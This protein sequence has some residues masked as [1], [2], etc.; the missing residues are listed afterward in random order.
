MFFKFKKLI[1]QIHLWLGL[2][3]GLIVFTVAITG[4]IWTFESE[5]SDLLYPYRKVEVQQNK[6]IISI[7]GVKEKVKPYLQKINNIYYLGKNRTI[8]V[9][10]WNEMNG[11]LINNYVYLNPYTGE[12]L[13]IKKDDPSFFDVVLELHTSLLLGDTGT[14]IVRY[15]TLIFL[16][17]LISGIFLWWPRNKLN[18][19]QRLKFDW[20]AS[21]KWKRKNY[22]LHSILGFY[23]CWIIIFA[24]ITGLAWGFKWVDRTIYAVATLG[25]PFKDYAAVNSISN[26]GFRH[27]PDFDDSVLNFAFTNY[28]KPVESWYYYFPQN[29]TEAISLYLN[30]D[31]NTWYKATNYF[32]DQRTGKLLMTE[33]PE[34]FNNGQLIRNM[35]YDIH[36]G[37]ILGLPGPLLVFFGSLIVASLP[38]TGLYIWY[39]RRRKKG[40]DVK[41]F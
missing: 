22:D 29:E 30:P 25:E 5:I 20:K 16:L 26:S 4:A 36:I 38:I 21:T 15:A 19:K 23:A 33:S 3:S 39:G 14:E 8:Q 12:V 13:Y 28:N 32:F 24:T 7:A 11:K 17:L 27:I 10:E 37:K 6:P 34:S 2:S 35:Y 9:R 40:K 18:F 31:A 1:R 41:M